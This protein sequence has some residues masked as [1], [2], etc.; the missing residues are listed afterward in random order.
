[1]GLKGL[2]RAV[3]SAPP[4]QVAQLGRGPLALTDRLPSIESRTGAT[5]K[6]Y[7]VFDVAAP[8]KL[9]LYHVSGKSVLKAALKDALGP[10]V[11]VTGG[12]LRDPLA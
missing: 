8:P 10:T 11:P 5:R 2:A 7:I 9:P 4:A 12:R 3:R 6:R 1:M